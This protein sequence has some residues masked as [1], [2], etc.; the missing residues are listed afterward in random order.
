MFNLRL[1]PP[2]TGEAFDKLINK[3]SPYFLRV[4]SRPWIYGRNGQAQFGVDHY[5]PESK[6]AVQSKNLASMTYAVVLEELAKTLNFPHQIST[7]YIACST[8]TDRAL[9]DKVINLNNARVAEGLFPVEIVFWDRLSE[10]LNTYPGL[11]EDYTGVPGI[12]AQMV[13][14]TQAFQDLPLGR[15]SDAKAL[16][17]QCLPPE[18]FL[19]FL[20]NYDF[21]SGRVPS[22]Q[23][24]AVQHVIR[25]LWD[26]ELYK[27]CERQ[28]PQ[29][30]DVAE[31][32]LRESAWWEA[33]S[34]LKPLV[35]HL[36]AFYMSI[37]QETSG[38]TTADG[39]FMSLYSAHEQFHPMMATKTAKWTSTARELAY[40]YFNHFYDGDKA[41]PPF[42]VAKFKPGF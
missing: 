8:I 40:F 34:W 27:A 20:F 15:A 2:E 39:E 11:R 19:D 6:Q 12:N 24:D 21:S 10:I 14:L 23:F 7:Y 30:S 42:T 41:F 37:S 9:Q 16:V 35:P 33:W 13:S 5:H 28:N 31:F 1:Q 36:K 4:P 29:D 38:V 26:V 32:R 3:L 17:N 18:P 22:K 25:L